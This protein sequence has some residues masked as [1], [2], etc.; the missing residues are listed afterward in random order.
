M[1]LALTAPVQMRD[2]SRPDIVPEI[3]E[4]LARVAVF[5]VSAPPSQE[6]VEFLDDRVTVLVNETE[7][8]VKTVKVQ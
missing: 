7:S 8:N 1:V 4:R 5:E 3:T 2:H 6:G